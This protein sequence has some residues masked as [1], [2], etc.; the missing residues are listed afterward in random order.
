MS[1]ITRLLGRTHILK[2]MHIRSAVITTFGPFNFQSEDQLWFAKMVKFVSSREFTGYLYPK[3][4]YS[5]AVTSIDQPDRKQCV[6]TPPTVLITRFTY[7]FIHQWNDELHCSKEQ[8]GSL[9]DRSC[10][11]Q[12]SAFRLLLEY[13]HVY[14][15][16]T[17][18]FDSVGRSALWTC[19]L[20]NGV[21]EKYIF[22]L[23]ALPADLGQGKGIWATFP[24]LFCRQGCSISRSLFNFAMGDLFSNSFDGIAKYN[25]E[26][27]PV[28]GS[29]LELCGRYH[30]VGWRPSSYSS[31]FKPLGHV[32]HHV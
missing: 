26:L 17:I 29:W 21:H 14:Q 23:K 10:T 15:R 28:P 24:V 31:C 25:V 27:L 11:D 20:K 19:M 18:V 13:R 9:P 8:G 16:P 2:S 22:I 6:Q 1:R 4:S 3:L 30:M 32:C 7:N 12:T 5:F